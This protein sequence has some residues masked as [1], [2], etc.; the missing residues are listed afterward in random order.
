MNTLVASSPDRH[1]PALLEAELLVEGDRAV[2]VDDPVAGVDQ[3]AHDCATNARPPGTYSRPVSAGPSRSTSPTT[4]GWPPSGSSR[5]SLGYFAGGAGDEVDAARR[6]SRP[7]RRWRLRPRVLVDVARR[8]HRARPCSAAEVSMPLLVAPVAFQRLVDPDGEVGMAR[9][10][11]AAGT[12]MC[13]STIAT[14]APERG[15]AE[16][17]R[18]AALVSALLLPR[19]RRHA[20]ADRGGGRV[21]LR[22][23]R[24]DRRRA[25]R[26]AGASATCAPA[27]RSRRRSTSPAVAAAI[28]SDRPITL[29]GGV[30]AGRSVARLGRPRRRS[31]PT[32]G[33]RCCVKG[34]LHGRGR[35]RWRSSTA[36]RAW[37]S[38]TTAAASST[39]SRR[40]LDVAA[41]GGRGGRR[42]LRGAD[43]RRDPP[44]DR[45]GRSR[46]RS[47]P[48]RCWS[49]GAP[50]WGLAVGGRR[51]RGGCWSCSATSSSWRSRSRLPS[52]AA[53]GRTC[54]APERRPT[55]GA[56]IFGS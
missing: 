11:A 12:V 31:R 19:P 24:A 4:S 30:R 2:D 17:P 7:S 29:A 56:P 33:C 18:G 36:R 46:W 53:A 35:A 50:L 13:L 32:A 21:G 37:S 44:R 54:S 15:R 10:A 3:L 14:L 23:D 49:G 51:G 22:G 48:G 9:A 20:G 16:A 52:P 26:R 8:E 1:P 38:P 42:A 41:R 28:G 6:T 34:V 39:A 25:A 5:A 47:G 27:S 40:A 45:R 55:A 43:R